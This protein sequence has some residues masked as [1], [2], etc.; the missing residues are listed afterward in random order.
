[1]LVWRAINNVYQQQN[2]DPKLVLEVGALLLV[3]K[4]FYPI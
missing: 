2:I 3:K 1:M 4:A